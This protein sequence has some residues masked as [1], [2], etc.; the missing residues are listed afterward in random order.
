MNRHPHDQL[1]GRNRNA[2]EN[3]GYAPDRAQRAPGNDRSGGHEATRRHLRHLVGAA[4]APAF[5]TAG[6]L[7]RHSRWRARRSVMVAGP[8][9][10]P[11]VR[12]GRCTWASACGMHRRRAGAGRHDRR[13]APRRA[14]SRLSVTVPPCCSARPGCTPARPSG[15]AS[16]ELRRQ[17]DRRRPGEGV[18]GRV[19]APLRGWLGRR[20]DERTTSWLQCGRHAAVGRSSSMTIPRCSACG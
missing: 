16:A 5:G 4:I 15:S 10:S 11:A 20:A 12:G 7:G 6:G 13:Q 1:I 2:A 17:D 14:R 8:A 18:R 9:C 3:G 19:V